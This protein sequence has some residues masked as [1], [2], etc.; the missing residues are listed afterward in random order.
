MSEFYDRPDRERAAIRDSINA[1]G[2]TIKAYENGGL[3]VSMPTDSDNAQAI[4][5]L[6]KGYG[7]PLADSVYFPLGTDKPPET[8][9]HYGPYPRTGYP[10][11]WN[12]EQFNTTEE[13]KS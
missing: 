12:F 3:T 10:G 1:L 6:L 13:T 5:L 4:R 7:L 2:G 11:F 8:Q 9:R